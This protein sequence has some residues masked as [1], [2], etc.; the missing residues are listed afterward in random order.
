[1][2]V[3]KIFKTTYQD[4]TGTIQSDMH[5]LN[6]QFTIRLD[7]ILF[8][9]DML[10]DFAFVNEAEPHIRHT[11]LPARFSICEQGFLTNYE[12]QFSI[13]LQVVD[14]HTNTSIEAS[15]YIGIMLQNNPNKQTAELILHIPNETLSYKGKSGFFEI[16]LQQI[17]KQ[18][19]E[20]YHLKCCFGC[21]FSD[22]S[23]Y[24]QAFWGTML[25]YEHIREK[26]SQVKDKDEFMEIMEEY[27]GIVAETHLCPEFQIRKK[28]T[29]Y[30]G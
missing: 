27:N 28:G 26:Y 13:P 30:R 18:L 14:K 1:M 7:G 23:V 11:D 20:N 8:T 24:G 25:C 10:D 5:L 2:Q 4:A 21:A 12:M 6:R 9:S 19:P 22:Y 3:S 15:L 29:G 16:A 17:Q